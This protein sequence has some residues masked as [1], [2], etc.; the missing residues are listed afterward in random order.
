MTPGWKERLIRELEKPLPGT[1][2][3]LK[4][5]PDVRRPVS[6]QY[7]LRDAGV[8]L[9]LFPVES[10]VY[11][12]FIKRAEYDGVHSGQV[13]FPG[14]MFEEEDEILANT[15]L[16]EAQ[17]ETGIDPGKVEILGKLTPLHIPVSN[18]NVHAFIGYTNSIPVFIPD[19]TEVQYVI[20]ENVEELLK[21]SNHKSKVM[22]IL[23]TVVTV[24]YFDIKGEHVWGATAMMLS[25]FTEILKSVKSE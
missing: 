12:L 17:E 18:I 14:G 20:E 25:E 5:S 15:A 23:G 11:T 24:P 22:D 7:P 8:L 4:M 6:G 16:R 1:M 9:L 19:P 13:S 21:E 3:Q 2:A 10:I